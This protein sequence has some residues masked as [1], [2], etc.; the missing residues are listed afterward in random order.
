MLVTGNLIVQTPARPMLEDNSLFAARYQ[1]VRRLASGGMGVVYEAR[2]VETGRP[3]ALKVMLAHVADNSPA[4]ERFRLEARAT[5][6][7]SSAHV[8]EVLDA[9]VHEATGSPFLVMELLHG[10]DLA[11]RLHRVGALSVNDVAKFVFQAALGLDA[12][13]HAAI[14]HRDLKPSNLFLAK[15]DGTEIIKIL[16]LGVAKRVIDTAVTTAVV[17]TPLYMAPEQMANRK[18]TPATD[19]YALA[20]VAYSLLVG[21]EYWSAEAESAASS[22]GFALLVLDGPKEPAT[23]RAKRVGVDLPGAFDDWFRRATAIDPEKRFPNVMDAALHLCTALGVDATSWQNET[24]T[25]AP[26]DAGPHA[27]VLPLNAFADT[28]GVEHPEKAHSNTMTLPG[29]LPEARAQTMGLAKTEAAPEAEKQGARRRRLLGGIAIAALGVLGLGAFLL[30]N[31]PPKEVVV[32]PPVVQ[33]LQC[34]VAEITGPGASPHLADALAK[35]ACARLGIELGV[36][37]LD[38]KGT[39]LEIHAETRADHS[40]HVV[41]HIAQ[42]QADGDGKT[43]LRATNNALGKLA[44]LLKVPP[45][46]PQR[47]ADWGARDAAGALRIERAIRQK[48]FDFADRAEIAKQLVVTDADSPASH[49]MLACAMNR[50]DHDLALR[51]KKEAL[52]LLSKMPPKRAQLVQANLMSFLPTADDPKDAPSIVDSYVEMGK[53]PDFASL[54]TMCGCVLTGVSFPMADWLEKNAPIMGLPILQCIV[55]SGDTEKVR[56]LRYL[57]WIKASLPEW[58]RNH[59]RTLVQLGRLDQAREA[60]DLLEWL[61]M[62]ST[63]TRE[64]VTS[65]TMLAF[66]AF[67]ASKAVTTTEA[68]FGEP[69]AETADERALEYVNALLFAGK[70]RTALEVGEQRMYFLLRSQKYDLLAASAAE[71]LRL[72]RLLQRPPFRPDSLERIELARAKLALNQI[73]DLRVELLLLQSH[74]TKDKKSRESIESL[75]DTL[76]KASIGIDYLR[77]TEFPLLRHHRGDE[78]ALAVYREITQ[79]SAQRFAAFE[80]GL[81][82]ESIGSKSDAEKAY[83]L[84]LDEQWKL[85]F[86]AVAAR[87]RLADLLR[88]SGRAEEATELMKPVDRAWSDADTDLRDIVK[89]MK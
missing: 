14:V 56:T 22:I 33:S 80:A 30:R 43:L 5:A 18:I 31:G 45:M 36:P 60:E 62:E 19:E 41:V 23:E 17:G 39:P 57:D 71:Q 83:R 16:D 29:D 73:D 61:D 1:I 54:Y 77:A 9:G 10:E 37:W 69:D 40:A 27:R 59:I 4:R 75:L 7:V 86:D 48:A 81:A 26:S 67:E 79:P 78:A 38:P 13:H 63:N 68:S 2:H 28:V 35:G 84:L 76:E 50:A 15:R 55:G 88:A 47:I 42:Q 11:S 87:V 46:E 65:K 51:E 20:M 24:A 82:F 49:A 85:P 12:L 44:P 34:P 53:D 8:V 6:L 89:R 74:G 58:Q 64:V 66:G 70:I 25:R 72:R 21:R 3:C 52:A 32:P